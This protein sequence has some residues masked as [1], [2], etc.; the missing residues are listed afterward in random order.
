M[1]PLQLVRRSRFLA[2]ALL[3]G[4]L[5]GCAGVRNREPT[6]ELDVFGVELGSTADHRSIRGVVVVEEPCL[7]GYERFFEA[8]D[9]SVGYDPS[10]RVRKVTTRNPATRVWGIR[11]GDSLSAAREMATRAGFTEKGAPHRFEKDGR[12][13]TLL[14][15]ESGRVFGLTLEAEN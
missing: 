6:P 9:F 5:A 13:L 8:L 10:G 12:R 3:L 15:D 4:I 7:R 14:A 1:L 2:G 11:P